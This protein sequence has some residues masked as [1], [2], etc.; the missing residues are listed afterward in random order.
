MGSLWIAAHS[1]QLY[2][3][4]DLLPKSAQL[5][6]T[7]RY[8]RHVH[9]VRAFAHHGGGE[10]EGHEAGNGGATVGPRLG[11]PLPPSRAIAS[12]LARLGL[13]GEQKGH[14]R[15]WV[16]LASAPLPRG[17]LHARKQKILLEG[18][19]RAKSA[20]RRQ[21]SPAFAK[22]R[23]D[24]ACG[25]GMRGDS[26]AT[27]HGSRTRYANSS[28]RSVAS[29]RFSPRWGRHSCLPTGRQERLPHRTRCCPFSLCGEKY[30]LTCGPARG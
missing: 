19:I 3:E 13:S 15:S 30:W 4:Y 20:K 18:E 26:C 24:C 14:P 27:C 11:L 6:G 8:G 17:P 16:F 22:T 25:V 29:P 9:E 28:D 12:R 7:C 2:R 23:M 1:R 21:K 5:A 10:V